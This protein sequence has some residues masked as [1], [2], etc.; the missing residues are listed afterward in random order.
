MQE[1]RTY[2]RPGEIEK[3]IKSIK[4]IKNLSTKAQDYETAYKIKD[5]E[6]YYVEKLEKDKNRRI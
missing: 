4:E 1:R 5:L 2:Y 6:K 3:I